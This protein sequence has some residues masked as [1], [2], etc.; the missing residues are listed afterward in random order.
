MASRT[1]VKCADTDS[2]RQCLEVVRPIVSSPVGGSPTGVIYA[3]TSIK[4][5][6]TIYEVSTGNN[7]GNCSV[8]GPE[9]GSPRKRWVQR[10]AKR[11]FSISKLPN[12]LRSD[13]W[14][15]FM[16]NQLSTAVGE[17]VVDRVLVP[18]SGRT[19]LRT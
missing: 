2:T 13:H 3:T 18:L 15:R 1:Q 12:R 17:K 10:R 14:L 19:G 11:Q 7:A 9:N 5:G 4:S 6:S 8:A 16:H